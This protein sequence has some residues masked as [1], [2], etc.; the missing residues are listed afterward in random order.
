MARSLESGIER[1]PVA[2]SEDQP[3]QKRLESETGLKGLRGGEKIIQFCLELQA[4]IS[5][6]LNLE[7]GAVVFRFLSL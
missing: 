5:N 3:C 6:S 2:G 4:E 7:R 1:A